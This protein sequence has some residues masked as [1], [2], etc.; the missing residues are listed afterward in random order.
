MTE[1]LYHLY[2]DENLTK[3]KLMQSKGFINDATSFL[4]KRENYE[5]EDLETDEEV[6]D[7]YM[8][9][10]R[11]QNVNEATALRDLNYANR[12][13]DEDKK[14]FARLMDT[15]DRMDSDFGLKAIGDYVG[16]VFTAPSTYA[17]M[18]SF[19]AAKVGA[20]AANQG[21]KLGIRQA[22]KTAGLKS[23]V[24]SAGVEAVGAGTTVLA[25]EKTRVQTG[26]KEEVDPFAVGLATTLAATVGG[27]FGAFTGTQR[28][29]S[30][31]KAQFI[32]NANKEVKEQIIKK[33]FKETSEKVFT[34][35][36]TKQAATD[37]ENELNLSLK[38]EEL[39]DADS[40]LSRGDAAAKAKKILKKETPVK[41]TVAPKVS[42]KIE[43]PTELFKEL[44]TK[45][46]A[47]W[48]TFNP[49]NIG[50]GKVMGDVLYVHSSAEDLLKKFDPSLDFRK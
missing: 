27:G 40:A 17:G 13:N 20:V 48:K 4:I 3:E 33:T 42:V 43:K 24:A 47:T 18:F 15:Y 1:P 41:E 30:S 46:E 14:Q 39:M 10:F 35:D 16:G 12:A 23:A 44:E 26:I 31:N 7:A 19:G 5:L 50:G 28:A 29:M 6:Y 9:H 34:S 49:K 2:K 32:V 11:V 25:Q 45:H 8:E 36:K 37:F 22:L 21:V 38:V